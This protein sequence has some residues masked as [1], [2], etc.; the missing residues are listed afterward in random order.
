MTTVVYDLRANPITFD[1]CAFLASTF[2]LFRASG[3]SSF[4]LAVI[5][6]GFRNV[7]P[8]EKSYTIQDRL[9]RLNNLISPVARACVPVRN[10]SIIR[11]QSDVNNSFAS[12]T[13]PPG[14]NF[15]M[16]LPANYSPRLVSDLYKRTGIIP[17]IFNSTASARS[18]V[19]A[20]F[21]RGNR[22]LITLSPRLASHDQSRNSQLAQWFSLYELLAKSGYQVV[23]I[24]DLDDALGD[25]LC[26]NY[27]WPIFEAAAFSLD[28]RIAV[29]QAAE[30]NVI[31]SG[32]MGAIATYSSV[33]Y[34]ICNVL[35]ESN[36]V[37]N[38]DYF[39]DFVGLEV[40]LQYPWVT[41][42]QR[43]D[44]GFFEAERIAK[45]YIYGN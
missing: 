10:F 26:W 15:A 5:A 20:R 40:G 7:T 36:H 28:I 31:S 16:P 18:A 37:A 29:L 27:P 41:N 25:R 44:W 34:V 30:N 33:S 6:T 43:F 32:G 17:C 42:R 13:Y 11:S 4:D 14:F 1:F 21:A 39:R 2:I 9:W 45:Q 8:R 19:A 12:D 23:V 35:H 22:A 3:E 38:A 24:P